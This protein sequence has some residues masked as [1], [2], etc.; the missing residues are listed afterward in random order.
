VY[1]VIFFE[2]LFVVFV[3]FSANHIRKI[4]LPA[5]SL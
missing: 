4:Q 3:V 2:R 5:S 1:L